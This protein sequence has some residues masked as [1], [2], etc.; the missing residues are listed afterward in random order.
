ME[1][2]SLHHYFTAAH[3]QYRKETHDQGLVGTLFSL[4]LPSA[5]HLLDISYLLTRPPLCLKLIPPWG[6]GKVQLH[7]GKVLLA[8]LIF[9]L[10]SE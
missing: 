8:S 4:F 5:E 1:Q 3:H 7:C 10:I 6:Y 2:M 9:A